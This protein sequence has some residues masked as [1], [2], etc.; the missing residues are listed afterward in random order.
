MSGAKN[1]RCT[2]TIHSN[3]DAEL[4]IQE[5]TGWLLRAQDFGPDRG[6]SYGAEFG[7]GFLPSYPETT[8][9]I[10]CT[11]LALAE[12]YGKN[13]YLTRA[14]EM[15]KWESDIQLSTGAVMGGM[16]NADPTPA[17]FNTGMVLLGWSTLYEVT[18]EEVFRMSAQ[19]AG[20]WLLEMQEANGNWIRGNSQFAS[21]GSTVY[22]VKAAWGLARLGQV[23]QCEE[24]I[25]GA[26]RNAE[27]A[28]SKQLPNGWFA[29]CCLDDAERPLLHT[30]AYTMQGLVGIG[31]ITNRPDFLEAASRTAESL[32]NLMD[33]NGFI[34]GSI[35]RDFTG[36]VSWCCLTGT[37][38]TSIVWSELERLGGKK[39]FAEASERANRYLMA[40][41]D[42]SSSDP[43]IRGGLAGSWPV[44][45][46]YGRFKI[47]NWATKFF[48]DAL[49]IRMHPGASKFLA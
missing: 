30:I 36:A 19:R 47:L 31:K 33:E 40:R 37:A 35:R 44:S 16:F 27:F 34:P 43:S 15:G 28:L 5:A 18:R 8:G 48:I 13:E 25:S 14:I 32:V 29:D 38:Q 12:N 11:L 22:N 49:L 20:N 7:S 41:H 1:S 24:F 21:A 10:I 3:L 9:Y 23:L 46:R 6:V 39:I 45:G 26:V 4:H 42:I 17:V 2:P